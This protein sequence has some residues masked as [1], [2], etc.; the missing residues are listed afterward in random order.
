[1]I[2]SVFIFARTLAVL[3]MGG[4]PNYQHLKPTTARLSN[5]NL[6]HKSAFAIF[7]LSSLEIDYYFS[8]FFSFHYTFKELK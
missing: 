2:A 8:P 6:V 4:G 3:D 5:P 1:M 7:A